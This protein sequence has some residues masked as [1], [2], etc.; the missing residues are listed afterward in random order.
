MSAKKV[1]AHI[2]FMRAGDNVAIIRRYPG[3]HVEQVVMPFAQALIL[4][5]WINEEYL[6]PH[7]PDDGEQGSVLAERLEELRA[8]TEQLRSW[9]TLRRV[10]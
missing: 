6:D 4:A 8:N 1:M 3:G 9:G 7:D 10:A 5:D 2:E